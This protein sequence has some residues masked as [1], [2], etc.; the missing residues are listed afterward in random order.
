VKIHDVARM[1]LDEGLRP[2]SVSADRPGGG[3]PATP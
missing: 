2:E 3:Q 1:V